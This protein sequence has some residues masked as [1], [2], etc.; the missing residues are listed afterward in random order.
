M[1]NS[2]SYYQAIELGAP[3]PEEINEA[4]SSR[5]PLEIKQIL[6]DVEDQEKKYILQEYAILLISFR[7]PVEK[8]L[9]MLEKVKLLSLQIIMRKI[10]IQVR[11]SIKPLRS[12]R[13]SEAILFCESCKSL[14]TEIKIILKSR[15]EC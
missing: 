8:V 14:V 10:C 9:N 12:R 5:D 7:Y 2:N 6:S 4:L 15:K 3:K 1:G 13:A 11:Y